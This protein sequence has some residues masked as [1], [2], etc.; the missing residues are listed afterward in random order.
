MAAP[1]PSVTGSPDDVS[2]KSLAAMLGMKLIPKDFTCQNCVDL[3]REKCGLEKQVEKLESQN[4]DTIRQFIEA[5]NFPQMGTQD[6]DDLLSVE[7]QKRVV[8]HLK[9]SMTELHCLRDLF[10]KKWSFEDLLNGRMPQLTVMTSK[11]S[12]SPPTDHL[13]RNN[14]C[15]SA[16]APSSPSTTAENP[17]S[18]T[19]TSTA[20]TTPDHPNASGILNGVVRTS[21][22]AASPVTCS[23]TS[24]IETQPPAI[25]EP[26]R[27]S[28]RGRG[29]ASK[30]CAIDKDK[31][32]VPSISDHHTEHEQSPPSTSSQPTRKTRKRKFSVSKQEEKVERVG[33]TEN[34]MKTPVIVE[35]RGSDWVPMFQGPSTSSSGTVSQGLVINEEN[36]SSNMEVDFGEDFRDNDQESNISL[37]DH[38]QFPPLSTGNSDGLDGDR[39]G[40]D[41]QDEQGGDVE[42]QVQVEDNGDEGPP[43]VYLKLYGCGSCRKIFKEYSRVRAHMKMKHPTASGSAVVCG[44]CGY[45]CE[46]VECFN[47]HHNLVHNRVGKQNVIGGK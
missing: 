29:G 3:E 16:I 32:V 39:E 43:K 6:D 2:L 9:Q 5:V 11:A 23:S 12:P 1:F 46:S 41:N 15:S 47:V 33:E 27:K 7:F 38:A 24:A 25:S 30:N 4:K 26:L 10:K 13:P 22:A 36:S 40:H 45:G 18:S 21:P 14:I 42:Q 28:L 8:C 34:G 17:V 20:R 35:V 31:E 44:R 37:D 19:S